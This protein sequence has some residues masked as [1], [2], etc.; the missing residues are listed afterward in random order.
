[1]RLTVEKN[2]SAMWLY[3]VPAAFLLTLV[4]I[5]G[6]TVNDTSPLKSVVMIVAL[7]A[8]SFGA[9]KV[10]A[11]ADVALVF[12]IMLVW[13]NISQ[14]LGRFHGIPGIFHLALIAILVATYVMLGWGL[15]IVVGLAGL[16]DLGYV[17]F[18]A[19]GA[20]SYA[21]LATHYDLSFWICLPFAGV[22]AASAGIILGFPVLRLRGDYLAIVTL[23]ILVFWGTPLFWALTEGFLPTAHVAF[24]DEIFKSNSAILNALLTVLNERQ[25][26]QGTQ[27]FGKG[28]KMLLISHTEHGIPCNQLTFFHQHKHGP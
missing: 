18:Y 11:R 22:M 8:G 26:H 7:G 27:V 9:F 17:A 20:Y 16:L 2:W 10:A 6:S 25:F 12:L 19:V 1:M 4:V 21:L 14:V 13:G 3:T 15:N 5:A 23:G 28:R 24:L